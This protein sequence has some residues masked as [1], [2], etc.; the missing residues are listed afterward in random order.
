MG[1]IDG[2]RKQ[3]IDWKGNLSYM[4]KIC[5]PEGSAFVHLR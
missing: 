5:G 1:E 3:L 4:E 2:F